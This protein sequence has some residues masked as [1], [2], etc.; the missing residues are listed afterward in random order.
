MKSIV[1]LDMGPQSAHAA[2][3]LRTPSISPTAFGIAFDIM[4][5]SDPANSP[6]EFPETLNYCQVS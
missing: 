4:L 1:H 5:I 6:S 3:P 2:D